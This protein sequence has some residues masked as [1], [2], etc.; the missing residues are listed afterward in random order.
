MEDCPLA[1]SEGGRYVCAWELSPWPAPLPLQ[2][3]CL[4]GCPWAELL[5]VLRVVLML[6]TI[7]VTETRPWGTE[8]NLRSILLQ[9]W[10]RLANGL[11]LVDFP[12]SSVKKKLTNRSCVTDADGPCL[13][14]AECLGCTD[15]D[16]AFTQHPSFLLMISSWL[17]SSEYYYWGLVPALIPFSFGSE[18][19]DISRVVLLF[20]CYHY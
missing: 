3:H 13:L 9:F 8:L 12:P 1:L 6:M 4:L 20:Y 17:S 11:S 15:V 14:Q 5:F 18:P 19:T 7:K 10:S 2:C 16:F